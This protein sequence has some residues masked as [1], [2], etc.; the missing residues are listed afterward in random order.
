MKIISTKF[1]LA[2]MHNK[3]LNMVFKSSLYRGLTNI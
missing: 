3:N 2:E 1:D